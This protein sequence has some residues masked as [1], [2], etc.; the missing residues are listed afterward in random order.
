MHGRLIDPDHTLG[1]D[2][3]SDPRMVKAFAPFG[4]DGRLPA[5]P[6]TLDSPLEERIAFATIS[7]EGMGAILDALTANLP[8]ASGVTT[9]TTTIAGPDANDVTLFISRPDDAHSPLPAVVHLH[10]GGMALGS[11]AD[12]GYRKIREYLAA[13]GLV[14][15]GVEFRNS[16]GKLGPHPFPAGLNDCAASVRWVAANRTELGVSHLIVSGESGGGNLTLTVA[17]KAKR[18]GWMHEIAGCYAQCPFI[19]NRWLEQCDD[20]P[21]LEENDEYFVSRHQLAL[22]GS[23]YNPDGSHADDATCWA[24]AATDDELNGLPPHVISVNELDP[25]RDEGLAYYRRLVRAGVPAVG[26][27]VAGTC[28]GGDLLLGAYLPEVY[29]ASIRDVSGFAKSLG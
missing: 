22:L 29:E 9:T 2:P 13:T 15:V 17:H 19:S 25:L 8:V 5:A 4:L 24:A 1:T 11:A 14:V 10:G 27:V 12:A 6:L 3:R 16:G 23:I 28:H 7:E 26:R 21:S 20:L 18:E